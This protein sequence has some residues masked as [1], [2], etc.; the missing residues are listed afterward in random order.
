[1]SERLNL[2]RRSAPAALATLA[3]A[4]CAESPASTSE[5]DY[6]TFTFPNGNT[7]ELTPD[8]VRCAPATYDETV[9]TVQATERSGRY[10]VEIEVVPTKEPQTFDLPVSAGDE[11]SGPSAAFIFLGGRGGVEVSTAQEIE[12][13]GGT[14]KVLEAAC[15][16]AR[17]VLTVDGRLGSEYHDGKPVEV[18]GGVNLSFE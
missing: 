3:L 11:E 7:L 4:S 18:T 10:M 16:P 2:I 17:L 5:S 1:M 9:K 12:G 6:L 13:G 14:L 8:E 15:D